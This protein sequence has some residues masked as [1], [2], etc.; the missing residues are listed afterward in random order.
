MVVRMLE[1]DFAIAL[2]NYALDD[3]ALRDIAQHGSDP[4]NMHLPHSAVMYLRHNSQTPSNLQLTLIN[5]E[6]D[7]LPYRVPII[8]VQDFTKD[9]IFEK[10]LLI[11]LPFYI[12]RYEKSLNEYEENDEKLQQLLVEYEDIRKKLE[13]ELIDT[14]KSI[15][16]TDLIS[17]I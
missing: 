6:G 12:L 17:N 2:D 4:I 13:T 1:Y 9:A 16:Y 7:E 15:L 5:Q 14:K 3:I 10:H 8:K 11:L